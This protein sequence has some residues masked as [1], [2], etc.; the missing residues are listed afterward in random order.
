MSRAKLPGGS[1]SL[2]MH[3]SSTTEIAFSEAPM[4]IADRVQAMGGTGVTQDTI[5]EQAFREV[6]AFRIYDGRQI[7]PGGIN[8]Q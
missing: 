5:V 8:A 1:G 7:A 3:E 6:R 4:R 2:G